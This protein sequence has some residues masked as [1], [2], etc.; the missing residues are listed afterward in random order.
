MNKFNSL[1]SREP[2]KKLHIPSNE[3]NN[4]LKVNDK[5]IDYSIHDTV[6]SG[7]NK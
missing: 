3:E 4:F 2:S 1:Q 5:L 7:L 6:D